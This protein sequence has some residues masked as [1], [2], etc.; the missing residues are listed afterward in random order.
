[1]AIP[2]KSTPR[3]GWGPELEGR[4]QYRSPT[5]LWQFE[6]R[7][8]TDTPL[9]SM[10]SDDDIVIGPGRWRYAHGDFWVDWNP[11]NRATKL[12][13]KD[14]E[15]PPMQYQILRDMQRHVE[16]R[17]AE[18][19]LEITQRC[20]QARLDLEDQARRE[21]ERVNAKA[22]AKQRQ[23]EREAMDAKG[24]KNASH[25]IKRLK[26]RLRDFRLRV[27]ELLAA[28]PP[29]AVKTVFL[30]APENEPLELRS[31]RFRK[32]LS[33]MELDIEDDCH[34][35]I[36]ELK[37]AMSTCVPADMIRGAPEVKE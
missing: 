20:H 36:C 37:Y 8:E 22:R 2:L 21:R 3:S 27:K 30:I 18:M 32:R 6:P 34:R 13:L 23:L 4:Y 31:E 35:Q 10:Y 24:I 17:E 9:L 16:R 14:E 26:S 28:P 11:Y 12:L 19:K 33:L 15:M 25:R 1:M 29:R 7:Y 5:R